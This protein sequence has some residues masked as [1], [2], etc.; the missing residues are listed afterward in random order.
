MCLSGMWIILNW[1]KKQ[2]QSP[3]D[4]KLWPS[5]LAVQKNLDRGPVPGIEPSP[6][7]SAENMD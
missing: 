1:K 5:S 2:N 3:K 7:M 6:E 4:S